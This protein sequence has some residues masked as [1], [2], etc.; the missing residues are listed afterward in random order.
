MD[1]NQHKHLTEQEK[2]LRPNYCPDNWELGDYINFETH[3]YPVG[4]VCKVVWY[5]NGKVL[6]KEYSSRAHAIEKRNSLLKREIPAHIK[7]C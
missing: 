5:L 7:P 1:P 3:D 2:E 6:E 4:P